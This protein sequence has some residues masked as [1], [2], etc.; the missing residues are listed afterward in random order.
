MLV[1]SLR[2]DISAGELEN[3]IINLKD[4][5]EKILGKT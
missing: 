3:A 1:T 2:E 4:Q 5:A